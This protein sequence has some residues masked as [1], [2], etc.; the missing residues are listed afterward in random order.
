[1]NAYFQLNSKTESFHALILIQNT[2]KIFFLGKT[3]IF[4]DK[5]C[6]KSKNFKVFAFLTRLCC[7]KD[8]KNRLLPSDLRKLY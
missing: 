8:W 7:V 2:I 5:I 3:D 6:A 4:K 1:M